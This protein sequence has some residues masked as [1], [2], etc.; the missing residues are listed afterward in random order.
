MIAAMSS[1]TAGV[2]GV[3]LLLAA[4][5]VGLVVGPKWWNWR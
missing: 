3:A 5:V 4:V 1:T 2:I